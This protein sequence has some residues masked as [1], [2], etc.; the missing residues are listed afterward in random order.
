MR[1]LAAALACVIALAACTQADQAPSSG[2]TPGMT[3]ARQD[4]E[5]F[6][7][8]T[9]VVP[10]GFTFTPCSDLRRPDRSSGLAV[11]V[12]VPPGYAA[13]SRG[14]AGCDFTGPGFG[15]DLSL[16]I[17]P[18]ETL[19]AVKKREVD[20]F[21]DEGGDDSV[22]DIAYAADVPVFGRHRGERL[23]YYCYC[24]GQDLDVWTVQ[25][26]GVRLGWTTP[27]RKGPDAATSRAVRRSV[28]LVHSDRSTCRARG[29]TVTFRPPIPQTESIDSY[30]DRCHLYLR[31][32]RASL[33][34]YAEIEPRPS[35]T[36]AERADRLRSRRSVT[37][38]RYEP[39]SDRLTWLTVRRKPGEFQA[40]TGT[41]R[42]VTVDTGDVWVTWSARPS[43][44]RTEADDAR[45]LVASVRP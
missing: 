31:P 9:R 35:L 23:T 28:G 2:S 38:V 43:Q 11:R 12:S 40:P 41:W 42:A 21:E 4:P 6:R 18:L 13:A 29:L 5:P 36:L 15:R 10:H 27:H 30:R 3:A 20:P 24:D 16:S 8:A 45:R 44:W 37:D 19:E 34:R 14:G 17:G 1:S 22:S 32:G 7:P 25:A 26:R 39:G 33:L